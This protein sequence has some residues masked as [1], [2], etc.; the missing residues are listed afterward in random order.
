MCFTFSHCRLLCKKTFKNK[1][2]PCCNKS[3]TWQ[4]VEANT[5]NTLSALDFLSNKVLEA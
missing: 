5:V 2:H 3:L 4:T 1:F